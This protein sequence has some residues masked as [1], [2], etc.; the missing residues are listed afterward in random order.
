MIVLVFLNWKELRE[1]GTN[2][3]I[4][5]HPQAQSE[6]FQSRQPRTHQQHHKTFILVLSQRG[7][8]VDAA[9]V[10]PPPPQPQATPSTFTNTLLMLKSVT[11][12]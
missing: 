11:L 6:H 4:V 8:I 12:L 1:F 3:L 5:Q 7:V 2:W 9:Q 10:R